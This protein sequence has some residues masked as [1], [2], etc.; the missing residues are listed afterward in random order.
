MVH[1]KPR[2]LSQIIGLSGALTLAAASAHAIDKMPDYQS[3]A[4][5]EDELYM[6]N[7]V[8]NGRGK[9]MLGKLELPDDAQVA[10]RTPIYQDNS[11]CTIV[12][13]QRTLTYYAHGYEPL[14]IK[15]GKLVSSKVYD[16]G[17][18]AFTK[19]RSSDL[20]ELEAKITAHSGDRPAPDITVA[21]TIHND[22][23]L[24]ADHGHAGSCTLTVVVDKKK[25]KAGDEIT[26][27]DLSRIPYVL[28]LSAPGY[29][30][31]SIDIDPRANR[32]IDL[33]EITLEPGLEF[34]I[35]YLARVRGKDGQWKANRSVQTDTILCNGSNELRF[36]DERDGLG[37]RLELRL[38][39]KDDGAQASFFYYG[40]ENFRDLG[41]FNGED[42]PDWDSGKLTRSRGQPYMMLEDQHL[43]FMDIKD[44][45]DTD[46][47]LMF[48]VE[49]A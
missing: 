48:W 25:I 38:K 10:S 26:F 35:S 5:V 43:Y 32:D 42:F 19:A 12:Y 14:E 13:P 30:E 8:Y 1:H 15:R 39:P 47:Q 31:Q 6:V 28:E 18:H 7:E 20:R 33:G 9:V 34:R 27:E 36:T 49:R 37:N 41:E 44:I 22:A 11:F 21:L 23:Y 46:I 29:V 17:E 3:V 16:A 4:K 2:P 40:K 45:N 24:F